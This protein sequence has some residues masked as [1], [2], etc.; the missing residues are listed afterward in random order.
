MDGSFYGT[1]E[2]FMVYLK[3]LGKAVMDG[4]HPWVI[5]SRKRE[6]FPHQTSGKAESWRRGTLTGAVVLGRGMQALAP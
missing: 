6:S 5:S 1:T 2:R 4:E 3:G